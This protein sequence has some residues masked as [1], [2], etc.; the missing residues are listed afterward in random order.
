MPWVFTEAF[1]CL[2]V[3]LFHS[4]NQHTDSSVYRVNERFLSALG[5]GDVV[6]RLQVKLEMGTPRH[7]TAGLYAFE[8]LLSSLYQGSL[9][10][11]RCMYSSLKNGKCCLDVIGAGIRVLYLI[12]CDRSLSRDWLDVWGMAKMGT[13]SIKS[14]EER[15]QQFAGRSRP[16]TVNQPTSRP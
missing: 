10:L 7:V 4:S 12:R 13:S 9:P 2:R 15:W 3:R 16:F 11:W 1:K 8:R 5:E 14:A 6:G